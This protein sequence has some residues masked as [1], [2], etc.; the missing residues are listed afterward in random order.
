MPNGLY[1]CAPASND[2]LCQIYESVRDYLLNLL[3]W[4][5]N[6]LNDVWDYFAQ[7]RPVDVVK[8]DDDL[9]S[10]RQSHSYSQPFFTGLGSE[11][12]FLSHFLPAPGNHPSTTSGQFSSNVLRADL[13]RTQHTGLAA[14]LQPRPELSPFDEEQGIAG[15]QPFYRDLHAIPRSSAP[16]HNSEAA[17]AGSA[18]GHVLPAYA[19]SAHPGKPSMALQISPKLRGSL[20]ILE[21]QQPLTRLEQFAL[22][23]VASLP[24]ERHLQPSAAA[25]SLPV[26]PR[27]FTHRRELRQPQLEQTYPSLAP[28]RT[29]QQPYPHSISSNPVS[30]PQQQQQQQQPVPGMGLQSEAEYACSLPEGMARHERSAS[31]QEQGL[32]MAE[33]VINAYKLGLKISEAL[34]KDTGIPGVPQESISKSAVGQG[35]AVLGHLGIPP[36]AQPPR[37]DPQ[38]LTLGALIGE[39]GF[40]KVYYGAWRGLEVAVKV[41]SADI[42]QHVA[43]G[44]EFRRELAAMTLLS[45]HRNVLPLLGACMQPDLA[46]LVT[47]YCPRGSLYGMLHSPTLELT[48]AQVAAMCLGAAKGMQHLHA[49]SVLHRDLK[50]GNLLVDE[51]FNVRVADFGLSRV[52]H[53]LNTL[54]GGLGTFQYMAPEVMANQRYSVKADVYSFGVV[55]WECTARQVPYAGLSGIQA[56]LAVMHRGLRPDIPV[57]TPTSLAQLIQEC[58][59]PLPAARPS[60][61]EIAPRLEAMISEFGG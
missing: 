23:S 37:I 29:S 60:F 33:Q 10:P 16:Q 58:W 30:L 17:L 22:P 49:H 50:S 21:E 45:Q 3:S 13:Q 44:L 55:L 43:A 39:G 27:T 11:S 6:V 7:A 19:G 40:G 18:A 57:H 36:A 4:I 38:E 1:D 42:T 52:T 8:K 32:A 53:D 46:A 14:L 48:W 25:L 56:A 2:P 34:D 35:P 31:G 47:P 54:T 59:Q 41:M 20:P 5:R 51:D 61:V 15:T 26:A 9:W 12:A 28:F 24:P